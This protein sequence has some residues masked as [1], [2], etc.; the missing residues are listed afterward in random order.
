[1][2]SRWQEISTGETQ[3]WLHESTSEDIEPDR[4]GMISLGGRGSE[5]H[6]RYE[7]SKSY[8]GQLPST[9]T[10]VVGELAR[11]RSG[12]STEEGRSHLGNISL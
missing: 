6:I 4:S 7:T 11:Y 3:H 9:F 8:D 5:I 1:M 12:I 2:P 10:L